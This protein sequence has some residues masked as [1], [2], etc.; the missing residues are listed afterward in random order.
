MPKYRRTN[1]SV[2]RPQRQHRR[3]DV[4]LAQQQPYDNLMKSLFAGNEQQA[5]SAFLPGAKY[6]ETL[7]IEVIRTPMR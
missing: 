5:I 7:N 6:L 4:P 3:A 1:T 2:V